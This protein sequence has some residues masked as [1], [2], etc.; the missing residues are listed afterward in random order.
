LL[1]WR[2]RYFR[3]WGISAW[4]N[5]IEERI[6]NKSYSRRE[7]FA[8]SSKI[9]AA[10]IG[11]LTFG[12]S[13][14]FSQIKTTLE[15]KAKISKMQKNEDRILVAYDSKF[16]STAEIAKFIGKHIHA[17]SRTVDV[18]RIE[19]VI[20]LKSYEQVVIGSAI[21]YDKW[22][23]EMRE[24][25]V[26]HERELAQ[27]TVAFFLVCLVLTKDSEKARAKASTYAAEIE[28]LVPKVNVHKFGQFAGVLDYSKMSFVQRIGAKGIFLMLGIKEGD[29]RDWDAIQ[30]WTKNLF[31]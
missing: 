29:Y 26:K 17:G 12:K 1:N 20:D 5:K 27:K 22:L 25:V 28:E 6:M 2:K 15:D 7:F 14:S 18:K 30:T 19:D 31:F 11:L 23:P 16:G 8:N 9:A 4:K 3:G 24:F 13:I 21:Q 10:T